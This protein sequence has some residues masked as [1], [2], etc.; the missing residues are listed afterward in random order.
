MQNNKIKIKSRV[1]RPCVFLLVLALAASGCTMPFNAE[2]P[3]GFAVSKKK[4]N[5]LIY[6]PDGF[7]MR[8][9]TEKNNPKKD[10][11]FWSEALKTHLKNNG[12]FLY[13][14]SPFNSK[15]LE[16]TKIIWLMPVSHDYYKYM[17]AVAV[18]GSKIYIIEASGEKKLFDSY[19]EDMEKIISSVYAK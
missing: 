5:T 13:N 12:Y 18:K 16:G 3:A 2:V 8:I 7:K 17:T 10:T 1:I 6:S 15:N 9:K 14:E 19:E 11:L 4:G